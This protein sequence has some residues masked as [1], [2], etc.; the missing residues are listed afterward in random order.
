MVS[1]Y[2]FMCYQFLYMYDEF[3][4]IGTPS[5]FMWFYPNPMLGLEIYHTCYVFVS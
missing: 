5:L 2:P 1:T 4:G 3:L